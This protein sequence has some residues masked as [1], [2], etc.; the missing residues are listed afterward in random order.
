MEALATEVCVQR[1][2]GVARV[3]P[4]PILKVVQ[5]ATPPTSM[6][7]EVSLVTCEGH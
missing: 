1:E 6:E 2:G 7:E 5:E 4:A 3:G